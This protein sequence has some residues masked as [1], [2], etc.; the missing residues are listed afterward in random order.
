MCFLSIFWILRVEKI[1]R[2]S[3][4]S[5]SWSKLTSIHSFYSKCVYYFDCHQFWCMSWEI[6]IKY[7]ADTGTTIGQYSEQMF[8]LIDNELHYQLPTQWLGEISF[9]SFGLL[10]LKDKEEQKVLS[11]STFITISQ[12]DKILSV[13]GE[14]KEKKR[15]TRHQTPDTR[16]QTPDTRHQ[17][18][19][20]MRHKTRHDTPHTT[21]HTPHTT[22]ETQETKQK[23]R[24]IQ[25]SSCLFFLGY[26]SLLRLQLPSECIHVSEKEIQR[27]LHRNIFSFKIRLFLLVEV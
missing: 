24:E 17:K 25:L 22:N 7:D 8:F 14:T 23:T 13:E 3:H 6:Y 16:H 15:D 20:N 10:K 4:L 27:L 1:S 26:Y 5:L 11:I 21:H 9:D 18:K 12:W 2:I 19:H